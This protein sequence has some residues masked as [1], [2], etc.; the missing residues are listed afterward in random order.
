[1]S[2]FASTFEMNCP[3]RAEEAEASKTDEATDSNCTLKY[4]VQRVVVTHTK[5]NSARVL[6]I[7]RPIVHKYFRYVMRL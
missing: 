1:M 5:L 3:E 2:P 6:T 7:S 4:F